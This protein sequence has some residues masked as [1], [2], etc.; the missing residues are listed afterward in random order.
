M[1]NEKT[2][3]MLISFRGMKPEEREKTIALLF[4]LQEGLSKLK[5]VNRPERIILDI[6]YTHKEGGVGTR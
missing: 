5:K 1:T 2:F 4:S 3:R 6:E